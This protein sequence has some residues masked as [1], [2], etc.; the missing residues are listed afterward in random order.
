[1][2]KYPNETKGLRDSIG[3]LGD[4]AAQTAKFAQVGAVNAV[5]MVLDGLFDRL[6]EHRLF[7]GE[8]KVGWLPWF[9]HMA[10]QRFDRH[11]GWSEELLGWKPFA[12]DVPPSAYITDHFLWGFQCDPPGVE[13]R[14]NIGVQN[15]V[16]A[17]DFPHQESEYPNS[18]K[19]LARNFDGIPEEDRYAM[20]AGNCIEFFHLDAINARA[21]RAKQAVTA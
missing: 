17:T 10:D 4:V 21:P 16:W 20:V 18:N 12:R 19:V 13:M 8:T 5:Q 9:K 3:P 11:K 14:H 6:A 2:L 1:L 7:I 15:M